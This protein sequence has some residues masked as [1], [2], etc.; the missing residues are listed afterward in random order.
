ML[1]N[2]GRARFQSQIECQGQLET[3]QSLSIS[4]ICGFISTDV[5]SLDG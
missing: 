3:P 2:N 1:K 4:Q 5:F